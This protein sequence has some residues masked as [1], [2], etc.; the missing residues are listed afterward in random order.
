[1]REGVRRGCFLLLRAN[2]LHRLRR[3]KPPRP[4]VVL[5]P[6]RDEVFAGTFDV[7][8]Q[9]VAAEA[10]DIARLLKSDHA[11]YAPVLGVILR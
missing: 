1:M 6:T 10:D 3:L 9:H 7:E 5:M 2:R 4:K 8:T 11:W